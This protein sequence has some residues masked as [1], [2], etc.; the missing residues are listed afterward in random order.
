ML[1]WITRSRQAQ[2]IGEQ[3]SL[4]KPLPAPNDQDTSLMI[5]SLPVGMEG[6]YPSYL[7]GHLSALPSQATVWKQ[8]ISQLPSR[9]SGR[10]SQPVWPPRGLWHCAIKSVHNSNNQDDWEG[11]GAFWTSSAPSFSHDIGIEGSPWGFLGWWGG[12]KSYFMLP[13]G[14][15][16]GGQHY[17][18]FSQTLRWRK[19]SQAKDSTH[20]I[21]SLNI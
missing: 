17:R 2:G 4:G 15:N 9:K 18:T 12:R 3:P 5:L 13:F 10:L 8:D 16:I 6:K 1:G 14:G 11:G 19:L 20:I 21:P 7:S